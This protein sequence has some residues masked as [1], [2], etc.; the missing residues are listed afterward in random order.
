MDLL[1]SL[2]EL[3]ARHFE[4]VFSTGVDKVVILETPM[5]AEGATVTVVE[6]FARH[7]PR[8]A[9]LEAKLRDTM[10]GASRCL[11]G[12]ETRKRYAPQQVSDDGTTTGTSESLCSARALK[13]SRWVSSG[14]AAAD[15]VGQSSRGHFA[16]G[17]GP[18]RRWSYGFRR[19]GARTVVINRKGKTRDDPD[20]SEGMGGHVKMARVAV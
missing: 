12:S 19:S 4:K 16:D 2:V 13:K 15:E 6:D 11:L 17:R 3:E 5:R 8:L 14:G 10:S 7:L 1:R 18:C 9:E 20:E